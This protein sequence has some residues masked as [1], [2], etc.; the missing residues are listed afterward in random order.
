VKLGLFGRPVSH[1]RSPKIF[2]ALS[3]L[4]KR[5]IRYIAVEVKDA[6]FA[7]TAERSRKAGWRGV[8]VTIPFKLEAAKYADRL[9]NAARVMG[10]VNVLRFD[11]KDTVGH[12]T[13]GEGLRDALKF[14]GIG[15]SG[16]RVLVFGAGGAARAAGWALAKGGA[17]SVRFT[18]RTELTAKRLVLDLAPSFPKT[19]FSYGTARNADVWINATPLGL[20]GWPDK[21]PAPTSLRPPVAAV[22]LVY[23]RKTAFQRHAKRL[24][25]NTSDG[26]P[27]LVFQALRAYEFW[28]RPF[29]PVRRAQLAERLIKELS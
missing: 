14:M 5:P 2:S 7:A 20:K 11:A 1:S 27:M 8:N 18:N 23:G 16:I 29:G 3:H 10:A 6:Q 13:D 4:I 19:S 22:D 21:S 25:S 28:D 12:N 9:T 26:L 17:K 24:G 15:M